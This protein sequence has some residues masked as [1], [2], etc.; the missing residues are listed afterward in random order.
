[1]NR[2]KGVSGEFAKVRKAT[3]WSCLSICMEQLGLHWMHFYE[4]LYISLLPKYVK[5]M[6][7]LLKLDQHF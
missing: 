3:A 7:V 5:K 4:I 6:P 2:R 1:M